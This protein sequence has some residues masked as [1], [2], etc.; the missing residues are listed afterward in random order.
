MP[1]QILKANCSY[2][3]K[4]GD[5]NHREVKNDSLAKAIARASNCNF[6]LHTTLS[7]TN[8]VA[9]TAIGILLLAS[10]TASASASGQAI[11]CVEMIKSSGK[12]GGIIKN[13][14]DSHI[15]VQ[16]KGKCGVMRS[17]RG[18]VIPSH[19]EIELNRVKH[20]CLNSPRRH[21]I[22]V[23]DDHI[24]GV[25]KFPRKINSSVPTE[26]VMIDKINEISRRNENKEIRLVKIINL[27]SNN[28]NADTRELIF[29]YLIALEMGSG[30]SLVNIVSKIKDSRLNDIEFLTSS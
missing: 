18:I 28:I 14:C 7:S 23:I 8:T 13:N 10:L 15:Q 3:K 22:S 24:N 11:G 12:S 29:N 25:V 26:K 2:I 4:V 30:I 20:H 1:N 5:F 9:K 17:E 16:F 27:F 6:Q 21:E 19:K